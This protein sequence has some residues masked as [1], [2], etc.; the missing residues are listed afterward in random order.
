MKPAALLERMLCFAL[1]LFPQFSP[2]HSKSLLDRRAPFAGPLL[3]SEAQ[4]FLGAILFERLFCFSF[5]FVN[6]F[7]ESFIRPLS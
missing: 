6:L 1:D 2:I 7:N 4:H 3:I 5:H